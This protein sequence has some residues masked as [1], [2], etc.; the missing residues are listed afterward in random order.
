[1]LI[2]AAKATPVIGPKL[3]SGQRK[4]L[5]ASLQDAML[6]YKQLL[7][8]PTMKTRPR[9]ETPGFWDAKTTSRGY[10]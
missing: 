5:R 9:E 6:Y 8:N 7:G 4:K 3:S 1:M 10:G 2:C